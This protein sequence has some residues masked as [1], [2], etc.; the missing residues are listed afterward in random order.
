MVPTGAVSLHLH[1]VPACPF[2]LAQVQCEMPAQRE[3]FR[4]MPLANT[5]VVFAK[6]DVEHPVERVVN[7]PVSPY[8]LCNP[9]GVQTKAA[10]VVASFIRYRGPLGDLNVIPDFLPAPVELAF[11]DDTVKVTITLSRS[12]VEFFKHEAKKHHTQYQKMIRRLL[13]VYTQKHQQP[14]TES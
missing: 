12:S 3:V 7:R 13:D 9:L 14:L 6:G 11:R 8:A 2:V 1:A 5:A 10:D 4:R